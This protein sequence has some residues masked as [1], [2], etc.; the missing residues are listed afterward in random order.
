MRRLVSVLLFCTAAF[1]AQIFRVDPLPVLTISGTAPVGAAP[2]IYAVPNATI[3]LCTDT[4]CA[5]P[6]TAYTD[7][8]GNTA[9]PTYAQ[10]VQ[11]GTATCTST[12]GPLGQFGFWLSPGTYY[13]KV[14]T[15]GGQTFGN[16]PITSNT[17]GVTSL[18]AGTAISVNNGGVGAVTVT[19]TGVISFNS[20]TGTVVPTTGDYTYSQIGGAT[21][22]NTTK[23]QMAGT[24][25]GTNGAPLC[26]DASGN[27]TTSA[28][29]VVNSFN[30]RA[31]TVV[32][33]TG[34]YTYSQI[35]G[36]VAREHHQAAD[37]GHKL[38]GVWREPL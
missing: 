23:P 24:N 10:V 36:A 34:D 11:A 19:N 17:A 26:D 33:T 20:R 3:Q 29:S 1:G 9:C 27:A 15:P 16:Y 30:S 14:I 37:G 5:T 12:S 13:Y 21:Q 18:I 22:G 2:L 8:S 35:G 32:P 28:C 4:A 7:A 25:S 38:R 31:G 6:A